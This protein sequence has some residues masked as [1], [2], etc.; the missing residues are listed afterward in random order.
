MNYLYFSVLLA[1]S[2]GTLYVAK[3]TEEQCMRHQT[4]KHELMETARRILELT[5]FVEVE[6]RLFTAAAV[7]QTDA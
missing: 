6:V 1:L 7:D 2:R 4:A 3:V 5:K